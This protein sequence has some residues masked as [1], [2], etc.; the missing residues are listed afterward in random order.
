IDAAQIAAGTYQAYLDVWE[1]HITPI[2]APAIREVALGGPDTCTRAKIVWQLKLRAAS[3]CSLPAPPASGA[4]AARA[5]LPSTGT[6]PSTTAPGSSYRRLEN[7]LY[8]V[9]IHGGGT[10]A[11]GVAS[12]GLSF[13]FSR[14]NGSVVV[15]W[16]G[17]TSSTEL[18]VDSIGRDA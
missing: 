14:D 1:R 8:R 9:E 13:K 11:G 15:R 5:K 3:D 18:T 17:S 7:Q 6:N 16:L 10:L 4:L 2:E 12:A